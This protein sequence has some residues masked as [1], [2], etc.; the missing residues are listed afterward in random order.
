[1]RI[2]I[3]RYPFSRIFVTVTTARVRWRAA[4]E[5]SGFER[6]YE[7]RSSKTTG[8]AVQLVMLS[9]EELDEGRLYTARATADM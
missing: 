6:V 2:L 5:V 7:G 8:S 3:I 9:V 1:M 4:R